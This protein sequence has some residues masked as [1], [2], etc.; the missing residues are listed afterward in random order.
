MPRTILILIMATACLHAS[1]QFG[2]RNIRFAFGA[3][4][5]C[6]LR[7]AGESTRSEANFFIMGY[8]VYADFSTNFAAPSNRPYQGTLGLTDSY[9]FYHFDVGYAFPVRQIHLIPMLGLTQRERLYYSQRPSGAKRVLTYYGAAG[10]GIA[11]T[12][13]ITLFMFKLTNQQV[14]VSV[15]LKI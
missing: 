13:G 10:V 14:G 11:Y 8:N 3:G 12:K 1:A 2:P 5:N 7:T 9:R 4:Y 15:G 6:A